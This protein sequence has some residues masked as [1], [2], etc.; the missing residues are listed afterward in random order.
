MPDALSVTLPDK[1]TTWRRVDPL[2]S[3]VSELA[4]ALLV[5]APSDAFIA[6]KGLA[7]QTKPPP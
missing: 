1:V 7:F 2:G 6:T 4:P 5:S 3:M